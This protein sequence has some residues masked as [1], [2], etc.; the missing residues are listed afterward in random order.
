MRSFKVFKKI[1][2]DGAVSSVPVP[3]S[4]GQRVPPARLRPPPRGMRVL[5][6]S[7]ATVGQ[8]CVLSQEAARKDSQNLLLKGVC[9]ASLVSP[10]ATS[11]LVSEGPGRDDPFPAEQQEPR[12]TSL[13]GTRAPS[14]GSKPFL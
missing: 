13:L 1:T 12:A 3:P 2:P 7:V 5:A 4:E 8:S 9:K 11:H 10:T 6:A 14:R